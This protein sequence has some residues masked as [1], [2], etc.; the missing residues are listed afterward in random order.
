[1]D[2]QALTGWCLWMCHQPASVSVKQRCSSSSTGP[3]PRS[4]S[5]SAVTKS[6]GCGISGSSRL[7]CAPDGPPS[8]LSPPARLR[9]TNLLRSLAASFRARAWSHVQVGWP[10][11]LSSAG[12]SQ[13]CCVS[14]RSSCWNW[15]YRTTATCGESEGSMSA[16]LVLGS[17]APGPP[18]PGGGACCC[19]ASSSSSSSSQANASQHQSQ[20]HCPASSS[21]RPS[22]QL[23]DS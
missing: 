6:V 13:S 16:A 19:C 3:A 8:S 14:E 7:R 1:M 18:G 10:G 11:K 21:S 4:S 12:R 20:Y 23:N 9:N 15:S 2:R 5:P 17:I 22:E